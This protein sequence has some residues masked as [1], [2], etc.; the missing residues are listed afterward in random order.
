MPKINL[1]YP[2]NN[3]TI[4]LQSSSWLRRIWKFSTEDIARPKICYTQKF[5]RILFH[6]VL[7]YVI[8]GT[9]TQWLHLSIPF[10]YKHII[11]LHN[12]CSVLLLMV[13]I[14]K[15]WRILASLLDLWRYRN[16]S[17]EM[18]QM[19]CFRL[20]QGEKVVFFSTPKM[21]MK[22]KRLLKRPQISTVRI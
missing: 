21:S 20:Q 4:I 1:T 17:A 10:R 3:R 14:V 22:S 5:S 15:R 13:T 9:W 8:Q 12:L 11:L 2:C 7:S 6:R 18:M 16:L 19:E